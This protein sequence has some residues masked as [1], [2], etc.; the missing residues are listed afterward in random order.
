MAR[1]RSGRGRQCRPWLAAVKGLAALGA[2]EL[3]PAAR[4][5]PFARTE[6]VPE[7]R[8]PRSAC[9]VPAGSPSGPETAAFEAALAAPWARP[10]VVA[11]ASCTHGDRAVAPGAA[12]AAGVAGPHPE[13]D[14]LRRGPGDPARR[15]AAG[16]W[17]TSTR[18]TLVPRERSTSPTPRAAPVPP[19]AMVVQHLA[20][21]P[22]RR[23]RAGRGRRASEPVPSSRTPPTGSARAARAQRSG[24]RSR[25]ACL[26]FYATKNLPIGEGGAVCTDD[27]ELAGHG[28]DGPGCTA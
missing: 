17:S 27:A 7:A 22:V 20:G 2:Q 16:T 23:R 26:S 3:P 10:H 8:R 9:C 11:V 19:A 18:H 15:A 24:R 12:P 1:P 13:P 28:A 6:I 21:Y 4:S 25:A 14:V 5:V